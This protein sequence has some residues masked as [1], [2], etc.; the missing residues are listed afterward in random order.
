MCK[1]TGSSPYSSPAGG[2]ASWEM[3]QVSLEF[4][5]SV[6][7]TLPKEGRRRGGEWPQGT[8]E[9]QI[10]ST[11]ILMGRE[12]RQVDLVSTFICRVAHAGTLRISLTSQLPGPV[13]TTSEWCVRCSFSHHLSP[14]P[15]QQP[16]DWSLILSLSPQS[17]VS[18]WKTFRGSNVASGPLPPLQPAHHMAFY[19][20]K[21]RH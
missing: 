1:D 5:L 18:Y 3:L 8:V 2:E 17:C 9:M 4:L 20:L 13:S 12:K 15:T 19:F 16:P 11:S 6:S 7:H 10:L 14:D 21:R